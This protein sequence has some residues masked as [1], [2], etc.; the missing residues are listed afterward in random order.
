[1]SFFLCCWGSKER[2]AGTWSGPVRLFR[3]TKVDVSKLG[4]HHNV[5]LI[6]GLDG[7][8]QFPVPADV[9]PLESRPQFSPY[10]SA[11]AGQTSTAMDLGIPKGVASKDGKGLHSTTSAD[12]ARP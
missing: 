8:L 1:M 11:E 2:P 4:D 6:P 10:A 9:A 7:A 5:I 3:T 12:A